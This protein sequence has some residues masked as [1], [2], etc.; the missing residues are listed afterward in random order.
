MMIQNYPHYQDPDSSC[1]T[2]RVL[3]ALIWSSVNLYC[4]SL[5]FPSTCPSWCKE[6]ARVEMDM[7][8]P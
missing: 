3:R 6:V 7:T 4:T 2:P 8:D 5:L 1:P